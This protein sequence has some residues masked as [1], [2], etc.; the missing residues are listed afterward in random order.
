MLRPDLK[1]YFARLGYAG[2]AQPGLAALAELHRLHPQTIPF[3]NLSPLIGE[4]VPLDLRSL[5]EKLVA[6]RRGG[7]CFEH[8]LLFKAVLRQMGFS[9][10]G[11]AARVRWQQ[12]A[13]AIPARSHMLLLV[14]LDEGSYIADV[15]FGGLTL[16]APLRLVTGLEQRTPHGVFRLQ[17]DGNGEDYGLSAL[18]PQGWALLY[19][20]DLQVQDA[21]DYEHANWYLATHPASQFLTTLMAAR[22][23]PEGRHRLR[24][25][26]YSLQRADGSMR[27]CRLR[28][29][30]ELKA[31]LRS[32]LLVEVPD[33]AGADRRLEA[34]LQS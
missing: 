33:V 27:E 1:A 12:P 22:P 4:P 15:G 9:V 24:N 23:A 19:S 30:E 6:R 34:L 14:E 13:G 16:T 32:Q 7:W 28:S 2:D 3:E 10:A 11:L 21:A 8:N 18:L 20:F 17:R 29:L 26:N 25:G 5:Q 31:L